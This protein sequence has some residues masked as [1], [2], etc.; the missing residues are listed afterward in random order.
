MFEERKRTFS[1]PLL[2]TLFFFF[3]TSFT[4]FNRCPTLDLLPTFSANFPRPRQSNTGI[5][6]IAVFH[7]YSNVECFDT[8]QTGIDTVRGRVESFGSFEEIKRTFSYD[9]YSTRRFFVLVLN[10][11]N[12]LVVGHTTICCRPFPKT[13]Y[14]ARHRCVLRRKTNR[15]PVETFSISVGR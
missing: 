3:L 12:R 1:R 9:L 6:K 14:T 15:L 13:L 11:H 10:V 7:A 8:H 5:L 2:D 4:N